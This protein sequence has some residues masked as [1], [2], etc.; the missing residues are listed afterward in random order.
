LLNYSPT[1]DTNGDDNIQFTEAEAF[2]GTLEVSEKVISDF[3]GLEAFVNITGFNG[4]GNI[5]SELSLEANIALTSV[6]FSESPDLVNINLKNGNNTSI[7]SFNGLDCPSLEFVCVDDI[8]FAEV[9]FT[10]IDADVQF[11][12]DCEVLAVADFNLE[13]SLVLLPNPVSEILTISIAPNIKFINTE[14]YSVS[15]QKLSSSKSEQINMNDLA[16]G[17]YFVKV[18]TKQGSVTKKII[19]E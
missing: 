6:D 13:E 1:I 4:R 15:G 19:K 10:N 18:N 17:I 2:T 3:T 9:N 5:M 14:V 7:T 16:T 12:E 11:V 8:A